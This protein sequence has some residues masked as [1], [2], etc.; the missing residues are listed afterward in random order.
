MDERKR[1]VKKNFILLIML[2]LLILF[3]V[4]VIAPSNS[5]KTWHIQYDPTPV[6]PAA[7]VRYWNLDLFDVSELTI[8]DLKNQGVFVMCYF[9]AGSWENWRP[10]A[11][12]FPENC[13]GR[14]NGWPGER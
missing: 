6:N 3:S 14:K 5:I 12:Q 10:D 1:S 7:D 8:A 2:F 11:N 4:F 9:S 13:L